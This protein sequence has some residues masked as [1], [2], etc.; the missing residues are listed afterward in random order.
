MVKK[1]RMKKTR[2]RPM[3]NPPVIKFK[4]VDKS[5]RF[6]EEIDSV[7]SNI[8]LRVEIARLNGRQVKKKKPSLILEGY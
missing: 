3:K 5:H 7:C 2:N 1:V 4:P 8:L 6:D